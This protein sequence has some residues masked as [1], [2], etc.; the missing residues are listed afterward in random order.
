MLQIVLQSLRKAKDGDYSFQG[1]PFAQYRKKGALF[2]LRFRSREYGFC[3]E[4][5]LLGNP[6]MLQHR[7]SVKYLMLH[8]LSFP[9]FHFCQ[10]GENSRK[11]LDGSSHCAHFLFSVISLGYGSCLFFGYTCRTQVTFARTTD[12]F[13]TLFAE[14]MCTRHL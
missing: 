13:G 5:S 10:F 8:F 2:L 12:V 7:G 14:G 3:Q 4:S 9:S 11:I 6:P 1:I